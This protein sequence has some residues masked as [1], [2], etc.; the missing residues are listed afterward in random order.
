MPTWLKVILIIVAIGVFGLMAIG[1]GGYWWFKS[2]RGRFEEMGKRA[3][4]D[5]AQFAAAHDGAQCLQ[6]ALRRLD[7]ADGI[8]AEA[9]VR[10]FLSSC[11]AEARESPGMCDG[12]PP[13]GEIMRSA[14]WAV[15][16]CT[17]LGRS[18]NPCS[19]LVKEIQEHCDKR[20]QQPAP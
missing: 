13:D 11:M 20:G 10:V 2:N 9:E 12:V 17:Q 18:G 3:K 14:T 8:M 7:R 4:A 1:L 19:R 16:K 15:S 6:E 5:A